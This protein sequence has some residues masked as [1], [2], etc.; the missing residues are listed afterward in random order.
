[1][2]TFVFGAAIAGSLLITRACAAIVRFDNGG[3]ADQAVASDEAG[4]NGVIR[5]GVDLAS[6]NAQ[7]A[8]TNANDWLEAASR[9]TDAGS[10]DA[11]TEA[12][13]P[14][15]WD[16]QIA[17]QLDGM[18]AGRAPSAVGSP[19]YPTGKNPLAF[20]FESSKF[21][22][23]QA[24]FAMTMPRAGNC[25]SRPGTPKTELV[26]VPETST[27]VAG[28]GALGLLLL[29]G[30]GVLGRVRPVVDPDS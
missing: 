18:L 21:N 29:L 17:A 3:M 15:N 25:F 9:P 1:M 22:G 27:W 10:M 8:A 19:L 2:K 26:A 23:A 6:G 5:S 7:A 20:G 4:T 30:S 28:A 14:M 12:L 24:G 11:S 16:G 13:L